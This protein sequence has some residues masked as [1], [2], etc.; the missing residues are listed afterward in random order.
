MNNTDRGFIFFYDWGPAFEQTSAEN[1]KKLLLAIIDFAKDGTPPPKF[2]GEAAIVAGFIFPALERRQYNSENARKR[3]ERR[4]NKP[5]NSDEGDDMLPDAVAMRNSCE[6]DALHAKNRY[7]SDALHAKNR[8]ESDADAM[9]THNT[10]NTEAIPM[11]NTFNAEAMPEHNT[12][13]ANAL[14]ELCYKDKDIYKDKDKYKDRYKDIDIYKDA[15]E[16]TDTD[17]YKYTDKDRETPPV[18]PLEGGGPGG[19][20]GCINKVGKNSDVM[21]GGFQREDAATLFS[22]RALEEQE[23]LERRKK[24]IGEAIDR[25]LAL[26][27]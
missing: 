26:K 2:T 13:N 11:H 1:V 27:K 23:A 21:N 20:G 5:R 25:V 7:E 18:S 12:V 9:R 8:C 3:A 16:D 10:F 24:E 6:S 19:T 22:R 15:D 4:W 14:K 17:K